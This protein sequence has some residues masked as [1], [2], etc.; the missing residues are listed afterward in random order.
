ML[1]GAISTSGSG[2]NAADAA[3]QAFYTTVVSSEN[4][5]SQHCLLANRRLPDLSRRANIIYPLMI[6]YYIIEVNSVY[7]KLHKENS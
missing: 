2:E 3:A 4:T 7:E 1:T 6:N 5:K